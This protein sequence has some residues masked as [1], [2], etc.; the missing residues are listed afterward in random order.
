MAVAGDLVDVLVAALEQA[1]PEQRARLRAALDLDAPTVV[2][3]E[4]APQAY[5]PVTLGEV[6][7]RSPRSVRDAIRR[8]E[9]DAIKRGR[10]WIIPAAAVDRY[11]GLDRYAEATGARLTDGHAPPRRRARGRGPMARSLNR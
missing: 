11:A 2:T 5:T 4:A 1:N 7:G 8:G 10:G 6:L 9:L 3:E